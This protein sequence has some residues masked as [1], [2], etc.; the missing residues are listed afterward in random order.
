MVKGKFVPV[1]AGVIWG[2]GAEVE[3]YL[4]LTPVFR[5]RSEVNFTP[6]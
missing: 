2:G 5:W 1:H 4:F 6:G 3:L